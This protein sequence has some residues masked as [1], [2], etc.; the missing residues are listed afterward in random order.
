MLRRDVASAPPETHIDVAGT[1]DGGAPLTL[2][3]RI[4]GGTTELAAS[5]RDLALPPLDGCL[6]SLIGHRVRSGRATLATDARLR[7]DRLVLPIRAVVQDLVMDPAVGARDAIG[8][9]LADA[10][11]R[12]DGDGRIAVTVPLE[13]IWTDGGIVLQ[14]EASRSE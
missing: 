10:A 2:T 7:G 1:L 3:G 8:D 6:S 5:V 11:R 9:A 14:P 4:A 13:A 12:P